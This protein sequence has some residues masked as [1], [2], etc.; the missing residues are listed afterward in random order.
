MRDSI[1]VGD[2]V[3]VSEVPIDEIY[4]GDIIQFRNDNMSIPVIHRVHEVYESEGNKVFVTKGD[5]NDDPD[6]EPV[7]P[8][9]I[10]GKAIFNIPKVGWIPIAIKTIVNKFGCNI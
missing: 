2:I 3:L 1:D 10:M 7:M 9:Q 5:S 6:R 8:G 4:E